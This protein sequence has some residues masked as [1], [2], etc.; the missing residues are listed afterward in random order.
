MSYK[1][2]VI[3][4][5]SS[6]RLVSTSLEGIFVALSHYEMCA[7]ES[8][9]RKCLNCRAYIHDSEYK[10]RNCPFCKMDDFESCPRLDL[11]LFTKSQR[12]AILQSEDDQRAYWEYRHG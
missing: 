7:M 1:K 10:G 4:A 8:E 2:S 9:W 12:E 11:L 6:K 3:E 5:I